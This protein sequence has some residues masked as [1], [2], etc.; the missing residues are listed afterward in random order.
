MLWKLKEKTRWLSCIAD[1]LP[2][3]GVQSM[4]ALPQH[5][6]GF[7]CYH[8]CLLV[9]YASYVLCRRLGWHAKEAARGGLLHDLYL[10]DW[11]DRSLHSALDHAWNHGAA[12][13][14][15]AQTR[16]L[17]TRR[18]KD[19][20]ASHMFPLG[21][22]VHHCREAWAVG[23]MDKLC[24]AAELLGLIPQGLDTVYVMPRR[25]YRHQ[26]LPKAM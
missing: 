4:R 20:I 9:S 8:H 15:N 17:L 19:I 21:P 26:A 14:R 16:F 3:E 18:E 6:R 24:A 2:D 12:A 25:D 1:L 13:L 5:H 22:T 23:L 11:T 10:Y 7:S